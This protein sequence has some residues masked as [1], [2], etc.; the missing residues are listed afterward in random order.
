MHGLDIFFIVGLACW[1]VIISGIV[2]IIRN[3]DPVVME[4]AEALGMLFGF[5]GCDD[6]DD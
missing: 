5:R 3:P 4:E 1:V 6:D 2:Q